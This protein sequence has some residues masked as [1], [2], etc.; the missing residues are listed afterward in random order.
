MLL[1]FFIRKEKGLIPNF[2]QHS[3]L[4]LDASVSLI[5]IINYYY[6]GMVSMVRATNPLDH[7]PNVYTKQSFLQLL[8]VLL[9]SLEM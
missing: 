2:L 1:S 6:S 8:H 9:T 7:A 3:H 5:F 4:A